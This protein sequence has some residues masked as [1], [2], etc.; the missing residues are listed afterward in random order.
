M[1]KI[2][3]D[4]HTVTGLVLVVFLVSDGM[5]LTLAGGLTG[6]VIDDKVSTRPSVNFFLTPARLGILG[7]S[8]L[9][10]LER[11]DAIAGVITGLVFFAGTGDVRNDPTTNAL[12]PIHLR[13]CRWVRILIALATLI[14]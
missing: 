10:T 9:D 12:P 14:W 7:T 11:I 13:A 2:N 5:E 1:E 8:R 6:H 4:Q 3:P